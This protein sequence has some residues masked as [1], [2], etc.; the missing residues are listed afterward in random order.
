M[1]AVTILRQNRLDV[2]VEGDL[3]RQG[4]SRL[5]QRRSR[6]RRLARRLRCRRLAAA[7]EADEYESKREGRY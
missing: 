3:L 7:D 5:H 1:A 4:N 2:L 6:F